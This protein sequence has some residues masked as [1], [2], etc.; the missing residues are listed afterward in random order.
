MREIKF[1]GQRVDTKEWIYGWLLLTESCQ[2]TITDCV[3]VTDW[4][5]LKNSIDVTA[6][7]VIPETVGQYTGLKD[8][9]GVEIYEGDAVSMRSG[10]CCY[11]VWEFRDTEVVGDIRNM[12]FL[13][14]GG[15]RE[16]IGNIHDNPELLGG[17]K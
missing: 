2:N 12:E 9:N 13:C 14:F 1:R 11:G 7:D 3:I 8:K 6:Y 17:T 10:E 5:N 16:V 4:E 15:K